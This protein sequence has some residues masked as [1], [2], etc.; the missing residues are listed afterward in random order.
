MQPRARHES[1]VAEVLGEELLVYDE[2][3]DQAYCLGKSAAL[4]WRRCDG[5]TGIRDIAAAAR[6]QLRL[7]ELV[8][9]LVALVLQKLQ[10]AKLLRDPL[11]A[12]LDLQGSTRRNRMARLAEFAV[13]PLLGPAASSVVA[14]LP[15]L[16]IPSEEILAP[17]GSQVVVEPSPVERVA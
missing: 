4:I 13:V 11:P 12:K 1:I 8:D 6:D 14:K 7:P 10:K 2:E 9:D 15:A 3:L 17:T 16:F 5:R